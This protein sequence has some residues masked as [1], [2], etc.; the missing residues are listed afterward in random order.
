MMVLV[1]A[2]H[3]DTYAEGSASMTNRRHRHP[4]KKRGCKA[5]GEGV[6]FVTTSQ[7]LTEPSLDALAIRRAGHAL[8]AGSQA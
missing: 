7:T 1:D 4:G 6:H 8:I 5:G 2:D 3:G